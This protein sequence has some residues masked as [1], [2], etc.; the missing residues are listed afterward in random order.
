MRDDWWIVL[1]NMTI[2]KHIFAP[3]D[4]LLRV[5][6]FLRSRKLY[7]VQNI[8]P[9]GVTYGSVESSKSQGIRTTLNP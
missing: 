1:R 7:F 2:R 3:S 9:T 6:E 4:F 8:K 5:D